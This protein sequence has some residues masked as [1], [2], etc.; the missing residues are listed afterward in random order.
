[1]SENQFYSI[2]CIICEQNQSNIAFCCGHIT[3]CEV[4]TFCIHFC[5]VC[6][7]QAGERL[8]VSYNERLNT[9][10]IEKIVKETQV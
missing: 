9:L 2:K 7:N 8:K 4:C 5:A 6:N 1:M 10:T 3:T